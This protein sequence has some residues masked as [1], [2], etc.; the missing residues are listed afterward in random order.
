MAIHIR[1][2]EFIFTL[3]GAAA[4]VAARGARA[5]G[6]AREAHRHAHCPRPRTIRNCRPG[7]GRSCRRWQ[8]LGWTVGRNVRIEYALGRRQCRTHSQARG[9]IGRARAGRH[10]GPRQPRPWRRCCRRPAPYRSC[11]PVALDPVGA[12]FVDSLAR[13]GGNATGFML[14]EYQL[15]REMAGTLKQIAPSVTRVAV[16]RDPASAPE[17]ASSPPSRPWRRRSGW[18][19]ARSMCATPARSSVPSRHSRARRMAA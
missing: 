10:P 13:P 5:A 15:E 1:R 14:F 6:R 2:R 9:G 7:S 8:Q 4:A 17:P 11:F 12:G 18:R 19:S 16:L 3:G